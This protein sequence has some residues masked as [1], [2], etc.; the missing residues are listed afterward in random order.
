MKNYLQK[1]P[2]PIVYGQ[3]PLTEFE[4]RM[5]AYADSN[6]DLCAAIVKELERLNENIE[7]LKNEKT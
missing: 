6:H 2:E 5:I 1:K 7:N 3:K 4:K